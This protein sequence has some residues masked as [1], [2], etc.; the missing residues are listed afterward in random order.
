MLFTLAITNTGNVDL[1]LTDL[2]DSIYGDLF[3]GSNPNV[4]NNTCDDLSGVLLG[5]GA[6]VACSFQGDV[7]GSAGDSEMERRWL[8][9]YENGTK[10]PTTTMPL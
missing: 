6:S 3:D 9:R 2:V 1:T 4:T 5:L 8:R 10:R 7:T